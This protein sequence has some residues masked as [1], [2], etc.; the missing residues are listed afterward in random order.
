MYYTHA[1]YQVSVCTITTDTDSQTT[2]YR[3]EIKSTD[4]THHIIIVIVSVVIF[5]YDD[6]VVS[7][8]V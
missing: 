6:C 3:I 8:N 2:W 4:I 5:Y 7:T 1:D